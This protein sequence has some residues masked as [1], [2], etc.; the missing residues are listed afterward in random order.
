VYSESIYKMSK[1]L[2]Q[3]VLIY[4]SR[5]QASW[6]KGI[7]SRSIP[8]AKSHSH[9]HLVS[10]VFTPS[11]PPRAPQPTLIGPNHTRPG[12]RGL[13]QSHPKSQPKPWLECTSLA[14][15]IW[16]HLEITW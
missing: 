16:M 10:S 1:L 12:P 15:G 7:L 2:E 4:W 5:S 11:S 14:L 13:S 9:P 6:G 3:K 8:R